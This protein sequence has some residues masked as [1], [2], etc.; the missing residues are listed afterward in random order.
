ME[1]AVE[2]EEAEQVVVGN[3]DDRLRSVGAGSS[4]P[5]LFNCKIIKID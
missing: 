4:D 3:C 2:A 5:A 1:V